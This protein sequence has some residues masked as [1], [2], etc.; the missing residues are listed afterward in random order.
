MSLLE[1][2]ICPVC[3]RI[4]TAPTTLLCGHSICSHHPSSVCNCSNIPLQSP[5]QSRV[6]FNP[7]PLPQ[8]IPTLP[9]PSTSDV[10]L[11]AILALLQREEDRPRKRLKRHHSSDDE[12]DGDGDLLT[13]LR[14]ATAHQR[15]I[16][17][18]PP[19]IQDSHDTEFDKKLLEELTCHICYVLFHKPVTTPCQHVRPLPFI[20]YNSISYFIPRPFVPNVYNAL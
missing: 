14:N 11:T 15:S 3:N 18:D 7:A 12:D 1:L 17:R 20:L 16:P 13:H 2:L 19:F 5:S 9:V 10:T 8:P 6:T 4:L